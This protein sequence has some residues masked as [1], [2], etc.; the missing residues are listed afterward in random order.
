MADY[1]IDLETPEDKIS[2]DCS[3]DVIILDAAEDLGIDLPYSCRAG[4][5][6]SCVGILSKGSVSQDDQNFLDDDQL[7]KGYILTCVSRPL[8]DCTIQT[9]KEDD[10][11]E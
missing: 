8:S 5:C 9:H 7:E 3:E 4:S 2:F 6:S 11:S 1:K 10:V